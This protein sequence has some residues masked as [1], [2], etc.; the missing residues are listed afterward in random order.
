MKREVEIDKRDPEVRIV[1]ALEATPMTFDQLEK[2]FWG[3]Y[4]EVKKV[5]RNK[6]PRLD[7]ERDVAHLQR[8]GVI[9]VQNKTFFVRNPN[10]PAV[11]SVP[12]SP[13][14]RARKK[15]K[16]QMDLI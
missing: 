12:Y 16:R 5:T 1:E 4:C 7:I 3:E 10:P 15:D 8:A 9:G 11:G 13:H 2:H 14:G 6:I